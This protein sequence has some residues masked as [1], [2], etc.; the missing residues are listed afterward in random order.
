MKV[1]LFFRTDKKDEGFKILEDLTADEPENNFF[2]IALASK[3]LQEKKLIPALEHLQKAIQVDPAD[4]NA[5][6]SLALTYKELGNYQEAMKAQQASIA[7]NPNR[8]DAQGVL[9]MLLVDTGQ[10]EEAEKQFSKF[11]NSTPIMQLHGITMAMRCVKL[12]VSKK[13]RKLIKNRFV[14]LRNMRIH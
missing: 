8:S 10:F 3:Y 13:L 5:Y 11:Y 7:I 14:Y 4:E 1:F 12:E 2:R 6:Q 9:G